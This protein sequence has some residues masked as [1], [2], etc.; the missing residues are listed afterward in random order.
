MPKPI[1]FELFMEAQ[2]YK[3][4]IILAKDNKSKIRMLL[5]GKPS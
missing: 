3:Q 2:G 5:N 1:F 4:N